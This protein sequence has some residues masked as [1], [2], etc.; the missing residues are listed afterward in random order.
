MYEEIGLGTATVGKG[1]ESLLSHLF[2]GL[3]VLA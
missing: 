2:L 1:F 3:G